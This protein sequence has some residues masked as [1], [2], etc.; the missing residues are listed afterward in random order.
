[1]AEK[2]LI[3]PKSLEE[4][5]KVTKTS[6]SDLLKALLG[7]S[8]I[9]GADLEKFKDLLKIVKSLNVSEK[10]RLNIIR[11]IEK[12]SGGIVKFGKEARVE[13]TNTIAQQE[14][15]VEL[16]EK[17]KANVKKYAEI[18][19]KEASK[20]LDT[21]IKQ[22]KEIFEISHDIQLEANMTWKQYTQIYNAAY[23][24][25]RKVNREV[26]QNITNAKEI[27]ATQNKLLQAGFKGLDTQTLTSVSQSV[28]MMQK[29]LGQ[30]PAE[31]AVA[32]QQSFRQFGDQTNQ[33]VTAIGNR[34]NAFSNT[35]GVSIGML[36]GAVAQMTANNSFL[37][38][39]NMRAQTMA[40]ENLMR[41]AALS[42]AI[43]LT[44]TDF[45]TSLAGTAQFGTMS[46][47]SQIFQGGAL[48][49]GF[50][51][52][53]FQKMMQTG[54]YGGGTEMLFSSIAS[55]LGSIQDQYLRAE[56]MQRIGGAFGLSRE[57]LLM[58]TQNSDKI[59][60]ISKNF[61][62]N[63]LNVNTSM[64]DELSGLKVAFIDKI[65]NFINSS[66]PAQEIGKVLQDL[67]LVGMEG[68]L[69][70]MT[71]TLYVIA[72]KQL[73]GG[74]NITG[75]L[76]KMGISGTGKAGTLLGS[77]F[78][79]GMLEGP[80]AAK[81][82]LGTMG[83]LGVAGA[84]LGIGVGG[85][86]LGR[87]IQSNTNLSD[88][89]ANLGGGAVNV[90]SAAAGGAMIGSIIPGI[91]T[92]VGAGIGAGVG[93][94]AGGINTYL[95]AKERESAMQDLDDQQRAQRAAGRQ[96]IRTTGDPVVDAINAMN[97]NLTNV[98]NGNFS[99]NRNYQFVVDM[100]GKTTIKNN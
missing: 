47:M 28:F 78:N 43:G 18:L 99:E 6:E 87:S 66:K 4:L 96:S 97:S 12:V 81:A 69:K 49:Q 15:L 45:L 59:P 92:L 64:V 57:D 5:S 32:F 3:N 80:T 10:E 75:M 91:G 33:F 44:S 100:Y 77:N 8:D 1:M 86:I 27:I 14:N 90:L 22:N 7:G 46:E 71:S 39:N 65:E 11:S 82:G 36:T 67:G 52:S 93:A 76:S 62:Q 40:N 19:K 79:F 13:L 94:I 70:Q 58:I 61:Q 20:A 55:T 54:E 31:L 56:Y 53:Q 24:A 26:G 42:G 68:Y 38:R 84:G 73:L 74:G 41:A 9:A 21:V 2:K 83:K 89:A 88:T 37:F 23:E 29:T 95:G 34:L 60:E 98:L 35:F 25:S 17:Q 63:L 51:T 85:N 48:L 72:A 16:Q 30:F 50:D